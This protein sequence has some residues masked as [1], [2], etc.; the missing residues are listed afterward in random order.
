[1]WDNRWV[2][3]FLG[4]AFALFVLPLIQAW[5]ANRSNREA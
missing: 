5:F 4:L 1:M 2:W 3:F